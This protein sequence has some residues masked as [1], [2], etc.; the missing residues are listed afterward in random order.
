MEL[1]KEATGSLANKKGE[2]S[3]EQRK[4]PRGGKH[5]GKAEAW[6]GSPWRDRNSSLK[7]SWIS[8][9]G[10]FL[11]AQEWPNHDPQQP[12][13]CNTPYQKYPEERRTWCPHLWSKYSGDGS[14]K[15]RTPRPSLAAYKVQEPLGPC[16]KTK[17][18]THLTLKSPT[19]SPKFIIFVLFS[20]VLIAFIG[21]HF[22]EHVW[23][24]KDNLKQLVSSFHC[25]GSGD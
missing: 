20:G 16:L 6:E 5:P 10:G 15:I 13:Q 25:V 3:G 7:L 18:N 2:P 12:A 24:S 11:C 4:Q 22:I 14:R 8:R 9:A 17:V 1:N 19:S 21:G 23:R